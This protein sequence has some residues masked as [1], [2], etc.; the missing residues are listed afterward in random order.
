M[1]LLSRRAKEAIKTALA[2]VI[3]YGI[4][5]GMGWENP[6]WAGFAVAMIS[7]STVGQSLNKGVMRMLGTLV[8][9]A[10]ALIIIALFAQDRWW[11]AGILSVYLGFCMYM[12]TGKQRTYFWWCCAFVCLII[13]THA[14]SDLTNA[15][16]VAVLRVQQ[17]GMGI[18]VYTLVSV[19]LWPSSTRGALDKATH[20]LLTTQA[21]IYRSYRALLNGQGTAEESRPLRLQQVQLL[22][23]HEQTLLA[24]KKDSYEV[25]ELR[26]RWQYFHHQSF[27]LMEALEQWRESFAEIQPLDLSAVLPNLQAVC[28]ELDWRFAAIE[29]MLSGNPPANCPQAITLTI[30]PA[31]TGALTHFQQAAV[32]VTRSQLDRLEVISRSLFDAIRDIKGYGVPASSVVPEEMRAGWSGLDADRLQAAIRTMAAVGIAFPVW[33]YL[34]PPGHASFVQLGLIF[35]MASLMVR[36][37]PATILKALLVCAVFAGVLYVFVMPQLSGYLQLGAMMF[38]VTFAIYYWLWQP[39][40][41]VAKMGMIVMFLNIIGVQNQQTY[42]FAQYA[43]T[44]AALALAG[45]LAIAIWYLPPSPRP[46]K[47]FLRTLQRF[48]RHSDFLISRLALDWDQNKGIVDHWK[49]IYYRSNLLELPQKLAS[50]AGKID[51]RTF[52]DN[53]PEQVQ[54]LVTSLHALAYRIKALSAMR[55]LPQADLLVKE[56]L[57]DVRAWRLIAEQQLQLWADNPA[58]ALG[59]SA[60]MQE[61]VMKRLARLEA[62]VEETFARVGEGR[63]S[64]EDYQNFYRL[65]GSFRGL[66]EAGIAYA[67]LA[68]KI[69]WA[70]WQEAR[71]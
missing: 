68:E 71:F 13:C 16:D 1:I 6:Y 65:L 2:M 52:P 19:F 30:D 58:M 4:S 31:A 21:R 55:D 49:T 64:S 70:Q 51:H 46:E 5:L 48:F 67:R 32:A 44:L 25:W 7:L 39:Q 20:K 63:L 53:S 45:A 36:L 29:G 61:R 8:A 60:E 15:F 23:Q 17:T 3:A 26:H 40:Q 34:D 35:L 41:A 54:A 43:N 50:W 18:L 56:L 27:A 10:A 47:Q 12:V 37:D 9:G 14:A 28:T 69:N 33:F 57:D 62:R 38:A 11:F 66:S 24:A 42:D 22:N 59:A